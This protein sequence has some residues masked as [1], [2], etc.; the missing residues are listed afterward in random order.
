M[1]N[2]QQ[3]KICQICGKG[4]Q[5]SYNRPHSLHKTKRVVLPNLQKINNQWVCTN[6]S[7]SNFGRPN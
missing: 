1:Q 4:P 7:K 3:T 6:C 2:N 5:A